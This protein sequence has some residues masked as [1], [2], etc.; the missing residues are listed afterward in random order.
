[1]PFYS[2]RNERN[3]NHERKKETA[4]KSCNEEMDDDIFCNA[5]LLALFDKDISEMKENDTGDNALEFC[6]KYFHSEDIQPGD[7]RHVL[8][9]GYLMGFNRGLETEACL[10]E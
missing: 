1:M 5:L 3:V 10:S 9:T 7:L 2:I 6:R 8:A 4:A